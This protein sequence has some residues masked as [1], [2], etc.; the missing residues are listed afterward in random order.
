M[1]W[2]AKASKDDSASNA[3]AVENLR[4]K[5]DHALILIIEWIKSNIIWYNDNKHSVINR[6]ASVLQQLNNV[7]KWINNDYLKDTSIADQIDQIS[8]FNADTRNTVLPEAANRLFG[9]RVIN[10][11]NNIIT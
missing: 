10:L 1:L 9:R 5:L 11:Y 4:N 6:N 8:K 2:K 3:S 7:Y